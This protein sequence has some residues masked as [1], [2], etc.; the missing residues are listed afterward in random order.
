MMAFHARNLSW[1]R[2]GWIVS[3]G[4]K[5]MTE[6]GQCDREGVLQAFLSGPDSDGVEMK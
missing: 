1:G 5:V 6:S 3:N 2:Y 4:L